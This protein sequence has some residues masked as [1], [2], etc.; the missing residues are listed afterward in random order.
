MDE[1]CKDC[2]WVVTIKD[3]VSRLRNDVKDIYSRLGD[4]EVENG[5]KDEKVTNL[6]NL[7]LEI[8]SDIKEI[9]GN[10]QKFLIG[11]VSGITVTVIGAI[12]IQVLKTFHW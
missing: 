11:I 8:K 10:K 5:K 3:D 9:K 2:S 12:I 7:L 1:K 4:V 6:E